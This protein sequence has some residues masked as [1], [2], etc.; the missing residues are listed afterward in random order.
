MVKDLIKRELL[1]G[2]PKAADLLVQQV[3]SHCCEICS[4]ESVSHQRDQ[5]GLAFVILPR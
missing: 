5:L 1:Y 3:S 4:A 2:P